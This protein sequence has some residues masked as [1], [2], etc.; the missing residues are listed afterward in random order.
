MD[1]R[2]PSLRRLLASFSGARSRT[3]RFDASSYWESRYASGGNSG[4]GSYGVLAAF[5]AETIGSLLS[6]LE[7]TSAIEFGCGDGNQLS[8]IDYPRYIGLDVSASAIARCL[9]KF[10]SDPTKSFFLYDSRAFADP[11]GVLR[12]DVALSLDVIYHITSDDVFNLYMNHLCDA[13][14]RALVIYSTNN[15]ATDSSHVRHREFLRWMTA[16]RPE[17]R[18]QTTITNPFPGTGQN[19]SNAAFYIFERSAE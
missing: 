4:E 5:K 19:Q 10:K 6:R 12:S 2:P 1:I 3:G 14:L 8:L 13:A 17:F 9:V 16:H 18:L 15:D 7:L 11:L